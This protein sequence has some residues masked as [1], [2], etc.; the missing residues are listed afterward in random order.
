VPPGQSEP[1]GRALAALARSPEERERLG[2]AARA[3]V[4]PRFGADR[5]VASIADLYDRLLA[6]E[7]A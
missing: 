5:Y 3:S 6:R 7:A 1:L 2:S 4:L